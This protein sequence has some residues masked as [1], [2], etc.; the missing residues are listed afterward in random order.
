MLKQKYRD[1]GEMIICTWSAALFVAAA[2]AA[3]AEAKVVAK[4]VEF[5][6]GVGN[7]KAFL[8][9]P[10]GKGPFPAIVVIHEWWGLSDWVKQNAE[11]FA[12]QGYAA[13]AI[14]LYKGKLATEPSEAHEL[15]RALDQT[16]VVGD[17]KGAVAFLKSLPEVARDK[18]VGSIGWCMGGG[19]SRELAQACNDIGPAVICY[20]SVTVDDSA[21]AKL[22]DKPIL[23]IFGADDRG[24]KPETVKMFESKLKE[25]SKAKSK[26][27]IYPA[28][29]HG[30]MRPGGASYN[31]KAT[32]EAWGEIDKFLAH[33]LK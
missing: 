20:G 2:T 19:Y 5:K 30:F 8:A 17:L 28:A 21:V 27:I 26:I 25:T 32:T 22:A 18:K 3:S 7:V 12:A 16:E 6:G 11:R 1:F 29:G 24:I 33:E 10:E 31:E 15:M 4:T 13:L 9:M 23:G 14:D